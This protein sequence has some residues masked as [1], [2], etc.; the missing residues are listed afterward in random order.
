[1][2]LSLREVSLSNS[3]TTSAVPQEADDFGTPRKSAESVPNADILKQE[4]SALAGSLLRSR[5]PSYYGASQVARVLLRFSQSRHR[6][7]GLLRTH[8]GEC[9][10]DFGLIERTGP[11]PASSEMDVSRPAPMHDLHLLTT[12]RCGQLWRV[13]CNV[14]VANIRL[15]GA[16]IRT[17]VFQRR[18][19]NILAARSCPGP[20]RFAFHHW[21]KQ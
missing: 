17:N 4:C 2:L 1:M 18:L 9:F 12:R 13:A 5:A 16:R 20:Q 15:I 21:S 6:H 14:T 7:V 19:C 8:R 11:D 3:T 10:R